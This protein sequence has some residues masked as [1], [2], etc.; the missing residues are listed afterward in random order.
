M[1]KV[2]LQKLKDQVLVQLKKN[3][4]TDLPLKLSLKLADIVQKDTDSSKFICK[5]CKMFFA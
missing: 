4:W 2:N 5:V 3:S 1:E